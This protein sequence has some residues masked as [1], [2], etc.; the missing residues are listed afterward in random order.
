VLFPKFDAIATA[1]FAASA[2]L[3]VP[4]RWGA[5]WNRNGKPREW[6]ETDRPHWELA[7]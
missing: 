3:G 4:I 7:R 2:E 5:D 6:G 1:M